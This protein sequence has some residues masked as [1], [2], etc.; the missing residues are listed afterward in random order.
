MKKAIIS[1]IVATAI[2]VGAGSAYLVVKALPEAGYVASNWD[3]AQQ[4]AI[5]DNDNEWPFSPQGRGGKPYGNQ[6]GNPGR[7]GMGPGMN[8][9]GFVEPHV[10]GERI[11]MDAALKA[12]QEYAADRGDNLRVAEIVEFSKNFY[13]VVVETDTGKGAFELLIHPVSGEVTPEFG[14]N[15][16]WNTKYGHVS[17]DEPS[18]VN[19]LTMEQAAA[20]AQKALDVRFTRA[21]VTPDGIDFY[22]YYSF[23]FEID[24]NVAG[25]LSVNGET[26]KV[27]FHNWHGDFI[28]EMEIKK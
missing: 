28:G 4:P 2:A 22:G 5:P 16:M 11:S 9:G 8:R 23:D 21:D 1:V 12:A 25:T 18:A 3:D 20:L 17:V 6:P 7:R 19:T 15:L 10:E 24:G 26:G 14:P 13:A 27:W